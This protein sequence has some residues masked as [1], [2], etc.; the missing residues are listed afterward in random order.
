MFSILLSIFIEW[1]CWVFLKTLCLSFWANAEL[2]SKWL[3]NFTFPTAMCNGPNFPISSTIVFYCLFITV[4]SGGCEVVSHCGFTYISLMSNDV[5]VL[6]M[7]LLGMWIYSLEK[8]LFKSFA[9]FL[10]S[11]IVFLFLLSCESFYILCILIPYQICDSQI[12]SP[13]L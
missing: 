3:F 7:C 9:H 2:F 6:F 11:W 4:N 10:I 5:E 1:N 12:F 13:I 8:H